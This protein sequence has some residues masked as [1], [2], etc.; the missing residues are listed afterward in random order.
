MKQKTHSGLKKRIKVRKS[1]TASFR[2]SSK[3]H[4]MTD[5]SKRQKKSFPNGMPIDATQLGRVKKLLPHARI[6]G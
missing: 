6:K 4:L 5:K 2:K 1:G 3:N